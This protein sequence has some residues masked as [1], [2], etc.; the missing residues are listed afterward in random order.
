[1]R[2][3]FDQGETHENQ[4]D[5]NRLPTYQ[6]LWDTRF[7]VMDDPRSYAARPSFLCRWCDYAKDNGGPCAFSGS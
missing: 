1:M 3:Y 2:I 5:R 4:Y 6:H 7:S